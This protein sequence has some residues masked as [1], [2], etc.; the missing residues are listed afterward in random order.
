MAQIR[1]V[2]MARII[3]DNTAISE[4]QP[5]AFRKVGEGNKLTNCGG[6]L[7]WFGIPSMDIS[8]FKEF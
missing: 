6:H 2:S 4:I 3:C 7:A 5:F 8:V 1:K